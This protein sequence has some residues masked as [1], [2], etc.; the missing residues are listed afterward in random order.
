MSHKFK[1]P[2]GKRI[3]EGTVA[4]HDT[5]RYRN[6]LCANWLMENGK[7]TAE[8]LPFTPASLLTTKSHAQQKLEQRRT[9]SEPYIEPEVKR[10]HSVRASEH[11]KPPQSSPFEFFGDGIE[12]PDDFK[13]SRNHRSVQK[14]QDAIEPFEEFEL[15][16]NFDYEMP[17]PKPKATTGSDQKR[18]NEKRKH[19][20]S[21]EFAMGPKDEFNAL[22][23]DDAKKATPAGGGRTKKVKMAHEYEFD[24][25]EQTPYM[26]PTKRSEVKPDAMAVYYQED[27]FDLGFGPNL[28]VNPAHTSSR[29]VENNHKLQHQH[30][31]RRTKNTEIITLPSRSTPANPIIFNI[32][33]E[34]LMIANDNE[35]KKLL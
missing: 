26:P 5:D 8:Y 34:N 6:S 1:K 27:R 30:V 22:F 14:H 28:F 9:T 11:H 21:L 17:K 31:E 7:A 23:D 2:A 35:Y 3:Y 12:A 33:C 20:S 24:H 10:K 32:R 16:D 4:E 18:R 29:R 19:E 25:R 15:F 13:G